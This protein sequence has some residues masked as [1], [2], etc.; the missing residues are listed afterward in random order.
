MSHHVGF[1]E[2]RANKKVTPRSTT[3]TKFVRAQGLAGIH[4]ARSL[5]KR[6]QDSDANSL[7]SSCC[8]CVASTGHDR[9]SSSQKSNDRF[10]PEPTIQAFYASLTPA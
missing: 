6:F 10:A 8:K 9:A 5:G 2:E 7:S 1:H 4:P 3:E